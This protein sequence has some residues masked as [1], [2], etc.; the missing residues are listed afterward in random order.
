MVVAGTGLAKLG[1]RQLLDATGFDV[2]LDL[3]VRRV[4]LDVGDGPRVGESKDL[5]VEVSISHDRQDTQARL[6]RHHLF[7]PPVCQP[8]TGPSPTRGQGAGG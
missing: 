3:L 8:R 5:S 1:A 4:E 2:D 6:H 7:E